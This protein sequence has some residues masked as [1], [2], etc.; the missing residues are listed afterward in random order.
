MLNV[1]IRFVPV[2]MESDVQDVRNAKVLKDVSMLHRSINAASA[3]RIVSTVL[4]S[5]HVKNVVYNL[6]R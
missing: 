4:K 6:F 1:T 5:M 3:L 2:N